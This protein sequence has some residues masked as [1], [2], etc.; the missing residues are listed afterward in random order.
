MRRIFVL[1]VL[2]ALVPAVARAGVPYRH[3]GWGDSLESLQ[4]NSPDCSSMPDKSKLVISFLA[5]PG[6]TQL[7]GVYGYVDLCTKPYAVLPWW[8][9]SPYTGCRS[10]SLAANANFAAGRTSHTDPSRGRG[11]TTCSY[12]P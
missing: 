6:V 4:D 7:E 1:I 10:D 3:M 11:G 12:T 8:T 5:P 2:L 9:F